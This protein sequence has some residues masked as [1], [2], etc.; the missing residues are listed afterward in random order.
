MPQ[1]AALLKVTLVH[2]CFSRFSNCKNGN[3]ACKASHV[4]IGIANFSKLIPN[5]K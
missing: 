4:Y 2:K 5:K 3:E 1:P